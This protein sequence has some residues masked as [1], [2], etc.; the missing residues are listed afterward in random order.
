[1]L[2]LD[3]LKI[4]DNEE[5]DNVDL[6][7][8]PTINAP[9]NLDTGN[10]C[11]L[12]HVEKEL[13]FSAQ[14]ATIDSQSPCKSEPVEGVVQ[15][16]QVCS[17]TESD[18]N[19]SV[20]G[21]ESGVRSEE[22]HNP[23]CHQHFTENT[24]IEG[25]QHCV[26]SEGGNNF[27]KS[28]EK[29]SLS[30]NQQMSESSG[31]ISPELQQSNKLRGN[32]SPVV[33]QSEESGDDSSHHHQ[34]DSPLS[35]FT[36]GDLVWVKLMNTPWWPA[37]VDGMQETGNK[38]FISVEF[39]NEN[40]IEFIKDSKK[41]KMFDCPEKET[42][43]KKGM[44][45]KSKERAALF[46]EAYKLAVGNISD[47]AKVEQS[48]CDR[49]GS[50]R[51]CETVMDSSIQ[52]TSDGKGCTDIS[53]E[54]LESSPN[55][56][57][58]RNDSKR[59][60]CD[61]QKSRSLSEN[62]KLKEVSLTAVKRKR[63]DCNKGA[64]SSKKRKA[65]DTS[66]TK[67]NQ[68]N[69]PVTENQSTQSTKRRGR[70]RSP[71]CKS[72][73]NEVLNVKSVKT[74]DKQQ[75]ITKAVSRKTQIAKERNDSRQGQRN[76]GKTKSRKLPNNMS[77]TKK[78]RQEKMETMKE[79]EEERTE[80]LYGGT[81]TGYSE[82]SSPIPYREDVDLDMCLS[83]QTNFTLQQRS[84]VSEKTRLCKSET[85]DC[86]PKPLVKFKRKKSSESKAK[87]Q[88]SLPSLYNRTVCR[89][90]RS[91][92]P[93]KKMKNKKKNRHKKNSTP[94]EDDHNADKELNDNVDSVYTEASSPIPYGGH[95]DSEGISNHGRNA[96]SV[97]E[98]SSYLPTPTRSFINSEAVQSNC[99]AET[100]QLIGSAREEISRE[101]FDPNL[102]V[103]DCYGSD[104]DDEDLPDA[105]T[106]SRQAAG[107]QERDIVWVKWKGCPV[108][109]AIVKRL[110]RKK[111]RILKVSLLVVEP[112]K[113]IPKKFTMN[114]NP[115]SILP[116]NS[117]ESDIFTEQGYSL[118]G[119]GRQRFTK[120]VDLIHSYMTKKILGTLKKE[121]VEF[122][123]CPGDFQE[124]CESSPP[125][126][127]VTVQE[128]LPPSP[129]PSEASEGSQEDSLVCVGVEEPKSDPEIAKRYEKIK[130]RNEP[131]VEFLKTNEVKDY[132]LDILREKKKSEKH[133]TYKFGLSKA[134][135]AL[136]NPGFGPIADESQQE[137]VLFTMV[138]WYKQET[139]LSHKEI[140]DVNYVLDVW[141]PEGIVYALIKMKK[142]SRKKAWEQ[143][144]K[145]VFMTKREKAEV[146][147]SLLESASR[148][149]PEDRQRYEENL[150][151]RMDLISHL[152]GLQNVIF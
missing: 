64:I 57:V 115:K 140:P 8:S 104:S 38:H 1:M 136:K 50:N 83:D 87:D 26:K 132:L 130:E 150:R 99:D 36:C 9:V 2:C 96:T 10:T 124:V 46:S 11:A 144:E 44:Q 74:I 55:S 48:P 119:E 45:T 52:S 59:N 138:N 151:N 145:G 78:K 89:K 18:E 65:Q 86:D 66:D 81:D 14:N 75:R 21:L 118:E 121:D 149:S 109:P 113:H 120:A 5:S 147:E 107:I 42:F 37:K 67:V 80:E 17:V 129:L 112:H 105:L 7:P 12:S 110:N 68:S 28:D 70:G 69:L 72:S 90:G 63:Q 108:W 23:S 41:I 82:S 127:P 77:R 60:L 25:S 62:Q 43:I 3:Q 133:T 92:K 15:R 134:R 128:A 131:L 6:N 40:A 126:S 16:G 111:K 122:M 93:S 95:V 47:G 61:N 88:D 56:S 34:S 54:V 141:I 125:L 106:P 114:Y 84:R 123:E 58:D 73:G 30:V 71:L 98:N 35:H 85:M 152:S 97:L 91:Q 31:N 22:P 117:K 51:L 79:I 13:S 49:K 142:Y 39:F 33:K 19:S 24:H 137:D 103:D 94:E 27:N 101:G 4:K 102:D 139:K 20:P 148:I 53:G 76:V 32:I 29:L 100:N 135:D 116:Y 146:H 143:F